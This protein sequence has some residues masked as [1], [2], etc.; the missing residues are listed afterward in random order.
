MT[1]Y[2]FM[3]QKCDCISILPH[4]SCKPHPAH[5]PSF[6]LP[7]ITN[8][9]SRSSSLCSFLHSPVSSS[10][11]GSNN[12]HS[13]LFSNIISLCSS[14]NI[15]RQVSHLYKTTDKMKVLNILISKRE[16]KRFWTEWLK[17]PP[18]LNSS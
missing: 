1:S 12:F 15:K 4:A 16:Y 18:N 5:R 10:L 14:V 11:L 13:T 3:Q 7:N 8:Y 6:E 2:R 17:F 9:K